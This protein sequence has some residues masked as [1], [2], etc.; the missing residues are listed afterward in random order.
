MTVDN[1]DEAAQRRTVLTV[2]DI[3]IFILTPYIELF[4]LGLRVTIDAIKVK[5][6]AFL[7]CDNLLHGTGRAFTSKFHLNNDAK[8]N[9]QKPT[10]MSA[11]EF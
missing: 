1:K 5:C 10:N 4:A 8:D 9:H 6:Y 7:D 2:F 3:D 11:G